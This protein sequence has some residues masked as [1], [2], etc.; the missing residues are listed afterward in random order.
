M[1]LLNCLGFKNVP[2]VTDEDIAKMQADAD[3]LVR[4]AMEIEQ[5]TLDGE[6]R[7]FLTVERRPKKERIPIAAEKEL[8]GT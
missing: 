8:C 2:R 5:A 1:N 6:E 7:W 3:D 4:R